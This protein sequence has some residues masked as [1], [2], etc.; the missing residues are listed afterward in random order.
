MEPT[1]IPT[2]QKLSTISNKHT[3]IPHL[4]ILH[5]FHRLLEALLR[6]LELLNH[7][8]DACSSC[9]VEHVFM[10]A[11]GGDEGGLEVVG[12]EE[13]WETPMKLCVS[14][15]DRS[16]QG[17]GREGGTYGSSMGTMGAE[18]ARIS[19][20]RARMFLLMNLAGRFSILSVHFKTSMYSLRP[21]RIL[22]CRNNQD[23]HWLDDLLR[24]AQEIEFRSTKALSL[25]FFL[26]SSREHDS[27]KA[28]LS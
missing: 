4:P 6:E 24:L 17:M 12:F 8:P 20:P 1:P 18:S 27:V 3:S 2:S 14:G 28:E 23:V 19:P 10:D 9:E 7:G 15:L 26:S 16:V 13:E 21:I 5:L 22:A 25:S 11:T